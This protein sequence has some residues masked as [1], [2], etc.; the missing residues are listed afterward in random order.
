MIDPDDD[1]ASGLTTDPLDPRLGRGGDTDKV[2][3]NEVYLVLSKDERAQGFIRPLR[4]TYRHTVCGGFTTMA[5]EIAETYAR[6]PFFYGFTYCV[7]CERHAPVSEFTWEGT[8]DI[9]GT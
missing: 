5:L 1:L 6:A 3:Q 2:P 9:V 8:N 7:Y 4:R